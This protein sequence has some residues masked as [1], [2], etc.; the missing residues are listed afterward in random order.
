MSNMM[1]A[2]FRKHD[3]IIF[4]DTDKV[5]WKGMVMSHARVPNTDFYTYKVHLI[6]KNKETDPSA[7]P[8]WE[9]I[10][11]KDKTVSDYSL[12]RYK[13]QEE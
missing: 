5:E 1:R 13:E 2:A 9:V 8:D 10:P 3:Q 11:L 6:A 12:R 4:T 7:K